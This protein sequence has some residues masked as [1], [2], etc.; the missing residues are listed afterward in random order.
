MYI[1]AIHHSSELILPYLVPNVSSSHSK[2]SLNEA[3]KGVFANKK[4][5]TDSTSYSNVAYERQ[6][7]SSSRKCDKQQ[8]S[9]IDFG[10]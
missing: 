6:I 10:Q 9:Q 5:T 2:F 4:A 8:Q 3:S 7:T 1:A